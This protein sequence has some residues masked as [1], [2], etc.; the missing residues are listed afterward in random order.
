MK[1]VL[2]NHKQLYTTP[3]L[4]MT[5]VPLGCVAFINKALIF[6]IMKKEIHIWDLSV[7]KIYIQLRA[8]FRE[9]F[10]DIGY[11]KFNGW[12]KFG[13]FFGIKR[14][15]TLMAINWRSGTNC[16][17]LKVILKIGDLIDISREEIEKNI[18]QVKYKTKINKRGGSSGK[19]I[20]DPRLPIKIDA[21]FI[22]MLGHI[23]GDGTIGI[24]RS[25]GIKISYINSEK[26]L[27]DYFNLLV[28]RVFGDIKPY[29][30]MR[31]NPNQYRRPNYVISYPSIVSHFILSVYNYKTGERLEFPQFV[32]DLDKNMKYVFLR[33]LFDDEGSVNVKNKHIKIGLKPLGFVQGIKN[34]LEDVG[35]RSSDV[36]NETRENGH[37]HYLWIMGKENLTFF[38]D[39]INFNH[40]GKRLKLKTIIETGWSFE[41]FSNGLAKKRILEILN[42]RKNITADKIARILERSPRVIRYHLKNMGVGMVEQN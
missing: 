36:K 25:K 26:Y 1:A 20:N 32:Y 28:K 9:E 38:Y 11:S 27:I 33:A 15:D 5:Y 14:A 3:N 30:E 2:L 13:E 16:Y 21:E 7:E 31:N 41:R 24:T 8:G 19:P 6:M 40:P 39:R 23:C 10:F 18:I 37:M 35:I 29:V 42:D 4:H 22:E 17:P 12:R 34:L